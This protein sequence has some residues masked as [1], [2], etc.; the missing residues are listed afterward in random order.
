M[1]KT[2]LRSCRLSNQDIAKA[3]DVIEQIGIEQSTPRK[4][5]V[6]CMLAM[7]EVLLS[8]QSHFGADTE[9]LLRIQHHFG[10]IVCSIDIAG[11]K[12]DPVSFLESDERGYILRSLDISPHYQYAFRTNRISVR[13][14]KASK[15]K[16]PT[17]LLL[18]LVLGILAGCIGN[19]APERVSD[20]LYILLSSLSEVIFNLMK[21]ASIPLIFLCVVYGITESGSIQT[22]KKMGISVL[23]GFFLSMLLGLA[24]A[25]ALSFP[26][27]GI[28]FQS[29]G[30]NAHSFE[31][32]CS[33]L[34]AIV[35]DNIFTPFTN[36]DNLKV[37]VLGMIFG[38]RYGLLS[39]YSDPVR[40]HDP[41]FCAG[42]RALH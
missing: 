33:T 24:A 8:F 28:T 39:A 20:V 41:V 40:Y 11:E 7:E 34:T 13:L 12:Y 3:I 27:F 16:D 1:K 42:F 6:M 36:G 38:L 29:G 5:L 35:P 25:T 22:F 10:V 19:A 2:E 37:I 9:F 23:N 17:I 30:S 18:S 31:T 26:V 4:V 14:K 15:L 21:M 32:L